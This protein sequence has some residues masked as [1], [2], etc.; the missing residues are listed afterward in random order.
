MLHD[1]M[2]P[3][4]AAR[5][6]D[7]NNWRPRNCVWEL[8]LAC[9]L[10]CR[11]CGS[12]AGEARTNELTLDETL[13][14]ADE[15][16]ELGCE[17]VT[18]SGGEPTAKK[19]WDVLAQR[20]ASHGIHVNMVTNGVYKDEAAA[21]SLA[22]RAR[23]CGLSN[24]G[25]SL[26]GLEEVHEWVRGP[27]T[28]ARTLDSIER[29]VA[30]G[31][32]VGVLTTVNK[33]N[34]GQLEEICETARQHGATMWRVQ[35]GKPMGAMSDEDIVIEPYR[36]VE[37]I[38]RLVALKKKGNIHVAVGD[39]IGYYG[40]PDRTLR[41]RGWRN[42]AECWQGCQAGMQAIGIEADGGV[43]GC[44]SL[45]AKVGD[46]DPFVE[47]NLRK[48]SLRDIWYKPGVFAYNRDFSLD[49]L[50]GHCKA[51]R[52]A[53]ICR[54]GAT[55]VTSSLGFLGEDPYCYYHYWEQARRAQRL[56]IARGLQ[57]AAAAM[58]I[59]LVV[60]GCPLGESNE[61]DYGIP[62]DS[63]G[64]T[65]VVLDA[66]VD[67]LDETFVQPEYGVQP[68][69]GI[70]PMD[71]VDQCS[72]CDQ[73]EYGIDVIPDSVG[74]DAQLEYGIPPDVTPDTASDSVSTDY[75]ILPDTIA[76]QDTSADAI[77]C[78]EVCCECEYGVIP[79]EVYKECCDPCAD[80]CCEC[81]YGEPPPE[82][83]CD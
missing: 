35:L 16:A 81:D 59:G 46:K 4:E 6:V 53:S 58:A 25:M 37:L 18:L 68:D 29:F 61:S 10:R 50:T 31:V 3:E 77:N 38:D 82:G 79:D 80:V 72:A 15:L 45:Q 71:V 44:L 78:D 52:Y 39:S 17:L 51:C 48:S 12:R 8:T 65:D 73:M 22:Q 26:D 21:L 27:G 43:K 20:I 41:G 63:V 28:F 75:G 9:N 1:L 33:K 62:P 60:S 13:R 70:S 67:A 64:A 56:R 69:Y 32:K 55:C 49:D 83:C 24:V 30:T 34:F 54:G 2:T 19:G 5:R 57:S 40:P 14:V 74:P 47:G 7:E 76:P 23:D 36:T 42:R 66:T 11:H